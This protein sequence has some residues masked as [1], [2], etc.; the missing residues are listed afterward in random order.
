LE[1]LKELLSRIKKYKNMDEDSK[2]FKY[3]IKTTIAKKEDLPPGKTSLTCIKCNFTCDSD[4][5]YYNNIKDSPSMD[6]NG[7]CIVCP[8]KCHYSYHKLLPY[9]IKYEEIEEEHVLVQLKKQHEDSI[10]N[11][12]SNKQIFENKKQELN[13]IIQEFYNILNELKEYFG[14]LKEKALFHDDYEIFELYMDLIDNN[15]I[16]EKKI[17]QANEKSVLLKKIFKACI[18]CGSFQ[19]F[20]NK[21]KDLIEGEKNIIQFNEQDINNCCQIF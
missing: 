21:V 2:N 13:V 20:K 8:G 1:T 9:C 16:N 10:A 15:E 14:R 3:K 17:M 12:D 5:K 4:S 6:S 18:N 11:L 19:D 7:H